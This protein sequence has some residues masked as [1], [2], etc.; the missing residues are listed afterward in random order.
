MGKEINMLQL[1]EEMKFKVIDQFLDGSLVQKDLIKK[2]LRLKRLGYIFL[3][4]K[5]ELFE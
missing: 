3:F 1:E 5:L 4:N 2:M